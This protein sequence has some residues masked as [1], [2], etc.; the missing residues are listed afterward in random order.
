[1]FWVTPKAI[2]MECEISKG[3]IRCRPSIKVDR[4]LCNICD[5]VT[6]KISRCMSEILI[7]LVI[8]RFR[9]LTYHLPVPSGC[10]VSHLGSRVHHGNSSLSGT[11]LDFPPKEDRS[12]QWKP[13][14]FL[15]SSD[16][17]NKTILSLFF[18]VPLLYRFYFWSLE[19]L[20][21]FSH[22]S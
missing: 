20:P 12:E 21:Y 16:Q 17:S 18:F 5:I 6:L 11:S 15:W 2:F 13:Q 3:K 14:V 7:S 4:H 9:L 19:L 1:M 22:R 10:S 8:L